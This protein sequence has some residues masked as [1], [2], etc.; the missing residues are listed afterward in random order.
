MGET[1]LPIVVPQSEMQ[2]PF[3]GVAAVGGNPAPYLFTFPGLLQTFRLWKMPQRGA[4]CSAFAPNAT[5]LCGA[6]R[7]S[8]R[9]RAGIMPSLSFEMLRVVTGARTILIRMDEAGIKGV[10]VPGLE[11]PDRP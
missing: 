3:A 6:C 1:G 7:W 10:A 9:R 4:A 5:E 8:C 11:M 2:K